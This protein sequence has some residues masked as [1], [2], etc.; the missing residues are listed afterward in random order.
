MIIVSNGE[1][2]FRDGRGSAVRMN[3]PIRLAALNPTTVVF[4]DINNHAI[5]TMTIDGWVRTIAGGPTLE[6]HGDGP[7]FRW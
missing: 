5:R 7:A 6:G 4:A 2:G 3:K 1:S